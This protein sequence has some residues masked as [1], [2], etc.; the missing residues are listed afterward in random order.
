MA[1][2]TLSWSVFDKW[3]IS[4]SQQTRRH[5][6]VSKA[7]RLYDDMMCISLCIKRAVLLDYVIIEE[8]CL[9]E[10]LK[11]C[12]KQCDLKIIVINGDTF[13]INRSRFSTEFTTTDQSKVRI[14]IDLSQD[15][16]LLKSLP[17]IHRHIDKYV[18]TVIQ[19][20]VP[21]AKYHHDS[22]CDPMNYCTVYGWLLDY[23]LIYWYNDDCVYHIDDV[24]QCKLKVKSSLLRQK[25]LYVVYI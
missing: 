19:T 2:E 14:F 12:S 10:L 6:A 4:T 8:R 13:I 22:L 1:R 25:V 9:N 24:V 18:T 11:L 7:E 5:V 17:N 15:V 23:P 20:E 16:P 3:R 21:S